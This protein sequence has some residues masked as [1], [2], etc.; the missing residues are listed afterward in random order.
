MYQSQW[1]DG[2]DS[3]ERLRCAVEYLMD[4]RGWNQTELARR[5]GKDQS[6][7]SRHLS[8]E[9]PPRGARFQF[10]DLDLVARVFGL[11][12]AELLLPGYGKWDRRRASERR[13]GTDRRHRR[14]REDGIAA[15]RSDPD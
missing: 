2:G 9:P 4:L 5:I 7:V 10:R 14:T 6:W 13:S 1:P 8:R 11:S 3:E 12:P 15:D